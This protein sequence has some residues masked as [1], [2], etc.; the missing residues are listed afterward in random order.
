M[1]TVTGLALGLASAVLLVLA[2]PPYDAWPVVFVALVPMLLAEHRIL[3]PRLAGLAVG[4]GVGG[5]IG[6]YLVD[7]FPGFRAPLIILA[8]P[9]VFGG[10][11]FVVGHGGRRFHERTGYRWFVMSGACGFVAFEL[12]RGQLPQTGTWAFLAYALHGQPWLIQPISVLGIYALGFLVVAVN[13]SLALLL[14]AVLDR[15][16]APFEGSVV[17]M[18]FARRWILGTALVLACWILGSLALFSSPPPTVRV[19]A[20]QP[21]TTRP[22]SLADQEDLRRRLPQL[23]AAQTREAGSRGAQIIVWPEGALAEDASA[24]PKAELESLARETGA[25]LV[26]GQVTRDPTPRGGMRNEVTVIA[27][28]GSFLGTSGKDHPVTAIGESNITPCTYPAFATPHGRLGA[29]ICYDGDFTDTARRIA[30]NGGRII[31]VP[32]WDWPAI[33]ARH[34]THFVFRAVENRVAIVKSEHANDSAIIDPWGRVVAKTVTPQNAAAVL[35]ADVPVEPAVPLAVRLGDLVGYLCA[36][37]ALV[38]MGLRL[39]YERRAR[40]RARARARS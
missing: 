11:A 34:Y 33:A 5:F 25:Y 24:G 10:L 23:L 17:S 15:R 40:A 29:M 26:V 9:L 32:S 38:F 35:V 7:V 22:R 27:P 3:R 36:A 19:A 20:L 18:R 4:C 30:A 2:F 21:G 12:L 39:V 28:D 1:S 16:K 8:L 37:G 13:Q 14:F 31:A 6:G